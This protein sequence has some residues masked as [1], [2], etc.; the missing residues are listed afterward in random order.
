MSRVLST[1]WLVCSGTRD[2]LADLLILLLLLSIT[3][4]LYL[5]MSEKRPTI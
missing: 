1:G 3:V 4:C 5:E 2:W